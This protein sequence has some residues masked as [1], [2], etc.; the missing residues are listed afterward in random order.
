MALPASF[1]AR[2]T[3]SF[4]LEV[5]IAMADR[6][7]DGRYRF[8]QNQATIARY[9]RA[10]RQANARLILDIQSVRL[11]FTTEVQA[12]RRWLRE[13]DVDLALDPE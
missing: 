3:G 13:P 6:G 11:P 2:L 5:T 8:P 7:A 10:A 4:E 9:L 1:G 12:L